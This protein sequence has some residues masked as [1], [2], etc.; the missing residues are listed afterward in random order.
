MG[1]QFLYTMVESNKRIHSG[2][3]RTT[4]TID[5][6]RSNFLSA[7]QGRIVLGGTTPTCTLH[8]VRVIANGS[9]VLL[10]LQGGQLRSIV[11]FEYGRGEVGTVNATYPLHIPFGRFRRDTEVIL[12]AK[13]FK[14]LQLQLDIELGGT[15]P[16]ADL[17]LAAEEY[18]SNDSP[19]SKRIRTLRLIAEDSDV[20]ASETLRQ[21]VPLG[22]FLRAVYLDASDRDALGHGDTNL[23]RVLVNN[24]AEIPF[25][26]TFDELE[27][28]NEMT[29]RFDDGDIPDGVEL[30]NRE[31]G[32][33]AGEE[34]MVKVDFD[35]EETLGKVLDTSQMNEL[36]IE[37]TANADASDD[38][39]SYIVEEIVAVG[40]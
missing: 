3:T 15:T 38:S 7:L 35:V 30:S 20:D 11:K 13:L 23:V 40:A 19:K 25:A 27:F 24:G 34:R 4:V 28:L 18:V 36:V 9:A 39:L 10:D 6:P 12:P 16:T 2:A 17:F 32:G 26:M 29:Y 8:R 1:G 14:S 22:N 31:A 37:T 5:L 33:T 21:K